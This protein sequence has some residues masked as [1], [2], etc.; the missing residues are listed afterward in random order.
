MDNQGKYLHRNLCFSFYSGPANEWTENIN[1]CIR[2]SSKARAYLAEEVLF[3]HPKRFQEYLIDCTAADVRHLTSRHK[4]NIVCLLVGS[5]CIQS[6]TLPSSSPFK[7]RWSNE[8]YEQKKFHSLNRHFFLFVEKLN[9]EE[10]VLYNILRLL[11][12][13]IP[14]NV[15]MLTQYF[16]FFTLYTQA[17][18]QKV[19]FWY[20]KNKR[21]Y[22]SIIFSAKI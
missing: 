22:W 8:W 7:S 3:Q 15:K 13:D 12:K 10:T 9:I 17:G 2:L 18:R 19:F 6:N 1:T 14:E 16:I 5:C 21:S 4:K 11:K 20:K